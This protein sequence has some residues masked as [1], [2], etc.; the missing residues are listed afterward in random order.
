MAAFGFANLSTDPDGR[1]RRV[2][3]TYIDQ[4]GRPQLSFAARAVLAVADSHPVASA[5]NRLWID[6]ATRP[7]D[8]PRLSWK[9]VPARLENSPALFADRLVLIG[10]EYAA[11]DD[12]H[13]VPSSASSSPVSGAVIQALITNT[14]LAGF[15]VRDWSVPRSMVATAFA[16]MVISFV[17][18]RF[19][20]R[21]FLAL[22]TAS[23]FSCGYGLFAFA[24]FRWSGLMVPLI[25]PELAVIL[26]FTFAWLW[27]SQLPPYPCA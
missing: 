23:A 9:D 11:S 26:S 14:I 6:Y 13:N 27:K 1:I 21:R 16:C 3:L 10:A 2:R 17:T 12:N 25:E 19:P 5:N 20:H 15:P 18:L 24:V 22:F 7:A 4:D 8:I